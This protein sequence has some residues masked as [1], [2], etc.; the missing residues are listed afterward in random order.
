MGTPLDGGYTCD[1]AHFVGGV[2]PSE[3]S[4]VGPKAVADEVEVLKGHVGGLLW[5]CM[6]LNTHTHRGIL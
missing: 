3:A 1:P 2:A 4:H 5:E 6:T